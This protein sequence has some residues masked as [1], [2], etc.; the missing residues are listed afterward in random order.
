ME[1]FLLTSVINI[2]SNPLWYS[3]TRSTF[4]PEERFIQTKE[5]ILQLRN[6]VKNVYIVLIEG[7][8]TPITQTQKDEL[9]AD[10]V[11]LTDHPSIYSDHKDHGEANQ[12]IAYLESEHYKN[13]KNKI[14]R[15]FKMSGRYELMDIFSIN[16]FSNDKV[17][18]RLQY[19][20]S[21]DI[22]DL[23]IYSVPVKYTDWFISRLHYSSSIST[24]DMEHTLFDSLLREDHDKWH[25]VYPKLGVRGVAAP[26]TSRSVFIF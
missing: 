21:P 5:Q 11:F 16:N 8:R 1:L 7:S 25:R 17:S 18:V 4:T 26:D 13:I 6:L 20:N 24:A 2:E 3:S 12:L 15:F 9:G 19:D 23:H 10:F 14:S 22:F